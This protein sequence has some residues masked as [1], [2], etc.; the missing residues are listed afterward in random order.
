[1]AEDYELIVAEKPRV[2]QKIASA[3]ADGNPQKKKK[4]K[5][6]YYILNRGE[7]KIVVAPAVG[8]IYTLKEKSGTSGYPIFDVEW[9][10]AFKANKSSAFTKQYVNVLKMLAKGADSYV[11]ACDY[12]IEGELI[13][14]NALKFTCGPDSLDKARRMKFSTLTKS[15]IE[16][17]YKNAMK[18]L[19]F[20]L[21]D[22]GIT[23]HMLDWYYGINASRALSYAYTSVTGRYLT[24]SA[25]R[26]QTPTLK[27][28]DDR[29]KEIQKFEPE[30][31]WVLTTLLENGLS[32]KHKKKKFFKKEEADEIHEKCKD[33]TAKISK[34]SKRKSRRKP[35]T[36]F[37]L[38][39]LQGEAYRVFKYNPKKTQKLAQNLYEKG[40]I[41]YP[42]TS[43]QKLPKTNIKKLIKKISKQKKYKKLG[44][45]LLDKKK[46]K[47]REGKKKDPAHPCIYPTGDRPKG[48]PKQEKK[49]YDLIV[50]RFF[51]TF[52]K[53]AVRQSQK[54]TLL[55][56]EETFIAKGIQTIKENWHHF[57][58]P[59]VRLK[60][61]E[62]PDME[63]GETYP[64][65]K[66]EKK[67]DETKPPKRYSQATIIKEMEK[68]GIGTK[69]TRAQIIKT[70]Y[71]RD[72]IKGSKIK[73]TEFGSRV[74]E[75][76]SDYVPELVSEELTKEFEEK[77]EKIR[78]GDLDRN[79]V[80]LEA[81]KTLKELI[82]KFKGHEEEIGNRLLEAHRKAE[83]QKKLLG[84][85]PKCGGN[86]IIRVSRKT[87][88]QFVGCSSYPDCNVSYPLPQNAKI[89]KT[90]KNCKH[91]DLPVIKVKRK[92]KGRNYTMCIDPDCP[93]KDDWGKKKK[94]KGKKK[95]KKSKKK[96]KK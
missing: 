39:D 79:K 28:L 33:G 95:G 40:L 74:V 87:G 50:K 47:A 13:G 25:G 94:K 43:S 76:I 67:E 45:E 7:K 16:K 61:E 34:I 82:E 59:Y 22:A 86:L 72:Y 5:V 38:G 91:D 42:R 68:L 54:I 83:K 71:S 24:L 46:L 60:E 89:I 69:S 64:V 3:L 31:F 65:D 21:A 35:P 15:E 41:S 4:G 56:T 88:K 10:P 96:N 48:V 27:I 17:S 52:G 23:R 18:N 8:H 62:L 14:Y 36:P 63:K 12:D 92:G 78:E 1:M 26:V 53:P 75:T 37:N 2:G 55:I 11:S 90:G 93:S 32:A 81:K 58:E 85:C 19:D 84:K 49:L 20:D 66:I 6:S 44:K 30:P 70:L 77:I 57:Y 29:E 73:V 80:I 51:A 9:V